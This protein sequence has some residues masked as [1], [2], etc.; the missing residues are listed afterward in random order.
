MAT[1]S[2]ATPQSDCRRATFRAA[3]WGV[4][5]WRIA[6]ALN[7]LTP[8]IDWRGSSKKQMSQAFAQADGISNLHRCLGVDLRKAIADQL[9]RAAS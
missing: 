9:T 1:Q 7:T 8:G 6:K 5:P 4:H 2:T 3:T